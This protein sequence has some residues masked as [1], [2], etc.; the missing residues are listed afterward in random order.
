MAFVLQ[1]QAHVYETDVHPD[2]LN[3]SLFESPNICS[4]F[5][6]NIDEHREATVTFRGQRYTIPPWS[7]SVLPDCRNTVFNTAKVGLCR[8]N[9]WV[10]KN[11]GINLFSPLYIICV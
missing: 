5:L 6:A 10:R 1:F 2:G 3:L 8:G 4:A 7:V 11:V 9:F